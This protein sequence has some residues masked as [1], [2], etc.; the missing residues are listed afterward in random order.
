MRLRKS[1]FVHQIPVGADSVLLV[2]AISQLKLKVDA[3]LGRLMTYFVEW[4]EFPAAFA[5]IAELLPYDD[6][7]L[8]GTVSALLERGLLTQQSAEEE[9][10]AISS[11]LERSSY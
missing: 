8:A 6:N 9:L 7:V 2:H 3:E 10:A 11:R 5:E 1:G 4:R